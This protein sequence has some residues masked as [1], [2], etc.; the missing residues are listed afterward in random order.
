MREDTMSDNNTEG[1]DLGRIG[2]GMM[3]EEFVP[4]T[5]WHTAGR[6]I[7][8]TDLVS[9]INLTWF[10][11]ELFTNRHD[12]S[13]NVIGGRPVPA[14]LVF[15][16]AEGLVS[17]SLDRTGLAFLHTDLDVKHAIQIGDTIY[18]HC[19]VIERRESKKL[20]R[21]LV[22]TENTVVSGDGTPLMVYRPLR[23][24]R[25]RHVSSAPAHA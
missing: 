2:I 3:W 24:V 17:P 19:K 15:T 22:R 9:F 12:Q 6:T 8:E 20:D 7:T 16:M 11:E 10:T 23:L 5:R 14:G 1:T 25:R 18:V 21:G 13:V 4:G